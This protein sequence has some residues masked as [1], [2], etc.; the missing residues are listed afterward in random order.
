VS[1]VRNSHEQSYYELLEVP[2]S[3]SAEELAHAYAL[4]MRQLD[5]DVPLDPAAAAEADALRAR[6]EEAI[7]VLSDP[8]ARAAYDRRLEPED[9]ASSAGPRDRAATADPP[10]QLAMT[11]ILASAEAGPLPKS[12][13]VASHLPRATRPAPPPPPEAPD[14]RAAAPRPPPRGAEEPFV[15]DDALNDVTRSPAPPR[16]P[17]PA[18]GGSGPSRTLGNAPILSEQVAIAEAETALARVAAHVAA[19]SGA[20]SVAREPKP[21]PIELPADAEIN[22]ELLRQVRKNR[23]LSLQQ[24]SERTR[25]STR[26]L[27]SVEADRYD[28]LPPTVY[29]RGILMNLGRELGLDP[30]RVARSYLD[31]VDRTRKP[32]SR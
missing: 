30:L 11:D 22:G 15:Q 32:G 9:Q 13:G 23:G 1:A 5:P 6:L 31:L 20:R 21:R 7:G 29:L 4:A 10:A 25:I 24:L 8:S 16:R 12:F 27:E 3:A 28:A 19:H 17:T 14:A 26:H 2:P 18:A